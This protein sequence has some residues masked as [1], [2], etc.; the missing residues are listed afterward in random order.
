VKDNTINRKIKVLQIITRSDWA[1]AQR[2]VYEICKGIKENFSS[3][4]EVE[5]AMGGDGPLFKLLEEIGV[6]THKMEYLRRPINPVSDIKAYRTLKKLIKEGGYDVVHCHSSK[7]GL[8]GRLAAESSNIKNIIY[9]VHGWWGVTQYKGLKKKFILFVE[10]FM[11]K[12]TSK[13][14]FVCNKDKEYAKSNRIGEDTQY[15]VIVNQITVP[16]F[17]KGKLRA[18]LNL[19]DSTKIVGNVARLSPQKNPMR[20]V[21]VAAQ[22]LKN[23][24]DTVFVWIGDGELMDQ[25]SMHSRQLGIADNI[26]F[27]G[28]HQN[29]AEL[30]ADFNCLLMTSDDEGLPITVLEA[31]AQGI[32]VVSTDV[33]GIGEL[34]ESRLRIIPLED[35]VEMKLASTLSKVLE[36]PC[37][38][39]QPDTSKTCR[40]V[41]D[42]IALY[43]KK[44]RGVIQ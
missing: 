13:L 11:A 5:V 36:E 8:I 15:E 41:E 9:T 21:E 30:M 33:G 44:Q 39:F 38:V 20:F 12:R 34:L 42:Y 7:A 22:V 2:I 35:F 28:F 3:E 10:R 40:M 1:G 26:K 43:K 31:L 29:G 23:R 27:V 25:A 17:T 24:N 16:K 37:T 4:I 6:K 32:P 19:S 14:V 18:M